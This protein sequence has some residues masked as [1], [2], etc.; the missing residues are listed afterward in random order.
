[1][2]DI[3]GASRPTGRPAREWRRF[4]RRSGA[5]ST[6][7]WDAAGVRI[8][9]LR[10]GDDQVDAEVVLGLRY[11][12]GDDLEVVH[13]GH[14]DGGGADEADLVQQRD[15]DV[16][17]ARSLAEPCALSGDC[18]A[19]ADHHVYRIHVIGADA[20]TDPGGTF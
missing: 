6:G 14:D 17:V 8:R 15:F 12:L 16:A 13:C 9:S 10:S 5:P 7:R 19:A 1:M 2:P 11:R 4:A 20:A 3:S 18:D